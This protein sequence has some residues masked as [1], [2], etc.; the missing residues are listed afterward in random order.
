MTFRTD[1]RSHE[2]LEQLRASL[3]G[4]FGR[5]RKNL[6]AVKNQTYGAQK[7]SWRSGVEIYLGH[8]TE[9]GLIGTVGAFG[10]LD[11]MGNSTGACKPRPAAPCGRR[12][13]YTG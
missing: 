13:E 4:A 6:G 7:P 9:I 2:T 11:V 1:T 10:F 8:K 5:T 12:D 3:V